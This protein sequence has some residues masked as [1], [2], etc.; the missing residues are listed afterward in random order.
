MCFLEAAEDTRSL[1]A[2]L[3]RGVLVTVVGT[4]PV[5]DVDAAA[6]T[7]HAAFGVGLAEMSIRRFFPEDFLVL[8]HDGALRERMVHAEH[9]EAP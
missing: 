8:C 1:E 4:R 9:V 3:A 2:E 5:V 6:A 7:L